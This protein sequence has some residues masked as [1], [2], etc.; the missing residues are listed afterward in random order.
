MEKTVETGTEHNFSI[1]SYY[2]F[3][4]F[5]TFFLDVDSAFFLGWEFWYVVFGRGSGGGWKVGVYSCC[6]GLVFFLGGKGVGSN[7]WGGN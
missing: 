6:F 2:R 4:C 3:L 1:F 7:L 5:W